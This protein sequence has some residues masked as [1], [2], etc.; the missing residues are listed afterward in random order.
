MCQTP[1]A[2]QDSLR[3]LVSTPH[4]RRHQAL[5]R[6]IALHIRRVAILHTSP[7]LGQI[8]LHQR[9]RRHSR[10]SRLTERLRQLRSADPTTHVGLEP[11]LRPEG[12]RLRH[13][14]GKERWEQD[15][16]SRSYE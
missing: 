3:L 15:Q 1:R 13:V 7:R 8:P 16:Y 9:D 11:K 12:G 4:V 10:R 5:H 6:R 14:F 2:L